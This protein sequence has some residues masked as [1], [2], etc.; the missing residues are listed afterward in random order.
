ML[1]EVVAA[2]VVTIEEETKIEVVEAMAVEMITIVIVP[3][4]MLLVDVVDAA[5]LA[6]MTILVAV[7]VEGSSGNSNFSDNGGDTSVNN[8]GSCGGRIV[9]KWL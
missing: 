2:V 6:I 8:N 9:P 4:V 7:G 5:V 1:V 3:E